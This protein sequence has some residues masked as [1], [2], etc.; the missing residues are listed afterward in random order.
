MFLFYCSDAYTECDIQHQEK[1]ILNYLNE[2]LHLIKSGANSKNNPIHFNESEL[3]LNSTF[4]VVTKIKT[5]EFDESDVFSTPS[6]VSPEET[7]LHKTLSSSPSTELTREYYALV[8]IEGNIL[9]KELIEQDALSNAFKSFI[10]SQGDV[11]GTQTKQCVKPTSLLL[12][13]HLSKINKHSTNC[14]IEKEIE[15]NTISNVSNKTKINNNTTSQ[16]RKPNQFAEVERHYSNSSIEK[17]QEAAYSPDSLITDEPSSSSDYL[18]AYTVSPGAASSGC[19]SQLNMSENTTKMDNIIHTSDSGLENTGLMESINSHKDVTLTDLSLTESTLHDI[20]SDETNNSFDASSSSELKQLQKL[21]ICSQQVSHAGTTA[22]QTDLN[23]RKFNNPMSITDTCG[24]S[25]KEEK[26]RQNEEIVILESSSLSSETGS[27]ESVFPPKAPV[28]DICQKFIN[29]ER[30]NSSRTE[31]KSNCSSSTNI[32]QTP[33]NPIGELCPSLV[34]KSPFKSS[35]CFIDAASL[36]DEGETFISVNTDSNEV[37]ISCSSVRKTLKDDSP[38]DCSEDNENEDSLEQVDNDVDSIQKDDSPVIFEMTPITEDSLNTNA[39]ENAPGMPDLH[40]TSLENASVN[41][42]KP[43]FVGENEKATTT[44]LIFQTSTPN[45]SII[46]VDPQDF[47]H[48]NESGIDIKPP[49]RE[50]ERI[51]KPYIEPIEK[52]N[53]DYH[54]FRKH[55]NESP[56]ISGGASIEDHLPNVGS[57]SGS[58]MSKRKIENIPIVSG[59]YIPDKEIMDKQ[60]KPVT[61]AHAWVVDMSQ[62][63]EDNNQVKPNA[64]ANSKPVMKPCFPIK[65]TLKSTSNSETSKSRSSV[66]SDSSEKSTHKF[67]IDLST[68]PDA[69][70]PDQ[71]LDED[72]NEKKNIFSMFIDLGDN[73]TV[74]KEMPAR[75]SSSLTKKSIKMEN[76]TTNKSARNIKNPANKIAIDTSNIE[77]QNTF[78]KLESLCNDPNISILDIIKKP[79]HTSVDLNCKPDE[80]VE[81]NSFQNLQIQ[82]AKTIIEEES[83][84]I[85]TGDLF[86][87][88]SDLDKPVLKTDKDV[89][90]V[91]EKLSIRMTRSIPENN[92]PETSHASNSRSVDIISSF[93][94]ENALSLNRL[95]PHLKNDFSKSMPGSLSS[96]TRSPFRLGVS[97]SPGDIDEQPSDASEIS[98]VQ[99]SMCRSVVGE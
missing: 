87:K 68:L 51:R 80:Q 44:K 32:H 31:L 89:I 95:F 59:A 49:K 99:S 34:Q 93:H 92:W 84:Q 83:V 72:N 8:P 70:P 61:N 3:S 79:D 2:N 14:D 6:C 21:K 65:D 90:P 71:N 42:N 7:N 81:G 86:V 18:S 54:K 16:V 97:S 82:A 29:H 60:A 55:S 46:S 50:N 15:C 77:I 88:L 75:L 37:G 45:N 22:S 10:K 24:T 41:L 28:N 85:N 38:N 4:S 56:I 53:E 17:T 98:S 40:S 48:L 27:W 26:Q 96:R 36:A 67:Y 33:I 19:F 69:T 23:E 5:K 12:T 58:P 39:Y 74:V 13:S 94:S 20:L 57:Y 73:S 76:K 91:I 9:E 78:E 47:P 11:N 30:Q 43:D 25:S 1:E 66:D 63:N 52:V 64:N 62:S 35:S